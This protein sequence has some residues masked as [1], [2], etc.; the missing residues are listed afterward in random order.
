MKP[1]LLKIPLKPLQSF[2]IR[3]DVVPYFFKELHFHP[4]VELVYIEQ[5]NGTQFIG[6][7][8]QEF[9]PGDMILVGANLPHM[10]KCDDA[11][12]M[13]NEELKASAT[14]IHFSPEILGE[15]FISLPENRAIKSLL[16]KA[17]MGIGILNKTKVQAVMRITELLNPKSINK[18][19]L[20]LELLNLLADS[21]DI[22][23]I[24]DKNIILMQNERESE[25]MNNIL[26]YLLSNFSGN[27]QLNEIATVANLTPNAF[28]RFFKQRTRKTFSTFLLEMRVSHSC[29]LLSETDKT[30]ANVCYESGFKNIS[31]FNRYF[32]QIIKMTPL[33]YR[34]NYAANVS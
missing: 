33:K 3:Q 22:H 1:K 29:K 19:L 6:N 15:E 20:L 31:N 23:V 5:G 9:G 13:D 2:S 25:K 26:Q 21:K 8:F 27:I 12:F 17:K 11:Y 28:C 14:V 34:N 32:K 18:I 30:V 24:N 4:E 16:S 7:Q 10:W